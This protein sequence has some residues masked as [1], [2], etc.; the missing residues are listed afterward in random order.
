VLRSTVAAIAVIFGLLWFAPQSTSAIENLI[1][2]ALA[3]PRF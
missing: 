3:L 1:T 2:S